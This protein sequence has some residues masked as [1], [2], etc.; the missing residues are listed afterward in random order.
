MDRLGMRTD[1]EFAE[2]LIEKAGVVT[3]PGSG[4]GAPAHLRLSFSTGMDNLKKAMER[5]HRTLSS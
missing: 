1:L 3:V 4:F 5:L 2:F